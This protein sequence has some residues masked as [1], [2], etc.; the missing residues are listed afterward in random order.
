MRLK[1]ENLQTYWDHKYNLFKQWKVST[2]FLTENFLACMNWRPLRSNTLG[3]LKFQLEKK[4][5]WNVNTY[6]NKLKNCVLF[7]KLL[8]LTVATEWIKKKFTCKE[9]FINSSTFFPH[10]LRIFFPSPCKKLG[11]VRNGILLPKL[12][13]PT[14]RKICSS[15]REKL[16]GWRP[17]IWK[18]F[19]ITW[20]IYSNSER[21]E[22]FLVTECFFN[23]FLE[24]PHI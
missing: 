14:V 13:W 8:L 21:S 5:H 12:F 3:K 9:R 6:R 16:W 23:L 7:R 20:T 2:I 17:R 11:K 1:F 4:D 15:D 22:Q 18:F 19:E 10:F 24:V